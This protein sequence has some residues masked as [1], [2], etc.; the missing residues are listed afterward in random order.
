MKNKF[1]ITLFSLC[2]ILI[3][4]QNNSNKGIVIEYNK[5]LPIEYIVYN[6]PLKIV[7]INKQ[8][9]IDYSKIGGLIQ[10]FYSASNLK[11]ALSDYLDKNITTSRDKEH[12]EAVKKTNVNKNYIQIETIY[13]F[14]YN[15][16]QFAY[17]KY[18]F[19]MDKV[20][21]PFI[22]SMSAEKH[23]NRW[24]I[25]N[26]L[27]QSD[28]L[29]FLSN[30]DQNAVKSLFSRKSSNQE[31]INIANKLRNEEGY[32]DFTLLNKMFSNLMSNLETKQILK[33]KR[34]I[35]ENT[36]FRNAV[37]KSVPQSFKYEVYQPFILEK[38]IFSEYSL[39]G[40]RI[41][42]DEK[43]KKR[44]SNKP[45]SVLLKEKP[46]SLI[47]KFHFIED[48]INYYIVKYVD[49]LKKTITI[50]E[51]SGKYSILKSDN[52]K[53]WEDLL[54][55]MKGD[56]FIKLSKKDINDGDLSKIKEEITSISKGVNLDLLSKYVKENKSALSKY[57]D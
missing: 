44:F 47:S 29:A 45:E 35:I 30:F 43:T 6:P 20:P 9:K 55:K 54:L 3:Y 23:E 22:G 31:I 5:L 2:Y 21:F 36:P 10:S 42:N 37:L 19:I 53:S 34:L 1:L 46:I 49:G 18:S 52:F 51:K 40:E 56:F 17:I 4:S 28:I 27:N 12:F 41:V 14:L 26:L 8:S 38:A 32:F 25:S 24:Y 7:Q 57:L 15:S 39:K 50:Q 48:N 13:K 11:W 16:K 33:D